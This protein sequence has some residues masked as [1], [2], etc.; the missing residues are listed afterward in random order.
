MAQLNLKRGQL[1]SWM[2]SLGRGLLLFW[3]AVAGA[4]DDNSV[5]GS[6]TMTLEGYVLDSTGRGLAMAQV[7]CWTEG[8]CLTETETEARALGAWRVTG[9]TSSAGKYNLTF[10]LPSALTQFR[11]EDR[12][13]PRIVLLARS[14]QGCC[15]SPLLLLAGTHAKTGGRFRLPDLAIGASREFRIEVTHASGCGVSELRAFLTYFGRGRIVELGRA[16]E[17]Q[18]VDVSVAIRAARVLV[19]GGDVHFRGLP[20]SDG[21]CGLGVYSSNCVDYQTTLSRLPEGTVRVSLKSGGTA[22]GRAVTAS[23]APVPGLSV[24][25]LSRREDLPWRTPV[26]T[27]LADGA[28]EVFGVPTGIERLSFELPGRRGLDRTRAIVSLSNNGTS[29]TVL[30]GDVTCSAIVAFRGRVVS[31]SG[32]P[33]ARSNVYLE[34]NLGVGTRV[35]SNGDGAFEFKDVPEGTYSLTVIQEGHT[36]VAGEV[37]V[38]T[39][40]MEELVVKPR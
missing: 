25:R 38:V 21:G 11:G 29:E 10:S 23:G 36:I 16:G 24:F 20:Q 4:C 6:A 17:P 15:E 31:S 13:A 22:R 39:Y 2:K 9:D 19:G 26:A 12:D 27:T 7:V 1:T 8:S 18:T 34:T 5:A 14:A 3:V 35:T 37:V 28:F 40:G 30:M 32:A 33:I